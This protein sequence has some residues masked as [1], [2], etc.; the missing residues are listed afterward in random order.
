MSTSVSRSS[1]K[2]VLSSRRLRRPATKTN[3]RQW[4]VA[5]LFHYRVGWSARLPS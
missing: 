5:A 1:N 4:T 2:P 3:R